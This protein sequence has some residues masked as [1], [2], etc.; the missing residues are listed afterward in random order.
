MPAIIMISSGA[1]RA[2]STAETPPLWMMKRRRIFMSLDE[3]HQLPGRDGGHAMSAAVLADF[4]V[5]RPLDG[6]AHNLGAA[7]AA[8]K[9][10]KGLDRLAG[11]IDGAGHF[12]I[13]CAVEGVLGRSGI[14]PV[15][16]EQDT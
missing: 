9:I 14:A 5:A 11:K 8:G 6:Q 2:N 16:E 12:R 7:V 10:T 15:T 4:G 1:A 3:P 13:G